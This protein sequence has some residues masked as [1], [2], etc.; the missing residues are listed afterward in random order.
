LIMEPKQQKDMLKRNLD[1]FTKWVQ[2]RPRT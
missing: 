2:E 1:W